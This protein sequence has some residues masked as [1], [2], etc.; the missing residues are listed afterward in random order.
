MVGVPTML[1]AMLEHPSF[2]STD[3]SSVK[4]I[5][6]GGLTVPAAL[7]TLFE[8]KLG[9]PFTI[10][11]GQTECSPV[12]AQTMSNDTIADRAATIGLPPPNIETRIINPDSCN[13]AAI[14]AICDFRTR[15][16]RGSVWYFYNPCTAAG[17]R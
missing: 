5:C 12:A 13:T 1:V 10:V 14:G 2:A 11:F 15:R 9:V 8:Q 17:A 16:H 3:L 4:A 6:S 7:V